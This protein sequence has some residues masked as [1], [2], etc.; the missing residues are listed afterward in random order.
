MLTDKLD[1]QAMATALNVYATAASLGGSATSSYGFSVSTYGLGDSTWNVGSDGAAFNV[2]NNS[3]LT[4]MQILQAWDQRANKSSKSIR[5][6]A[7]D[8]F[9][10]I[11]ARGGI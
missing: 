10:G 11:N 4:V 6:M 7:I 1:A 5:Q 9:G 2:D 3:T 8:V